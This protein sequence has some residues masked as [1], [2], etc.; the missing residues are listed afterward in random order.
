LRDKVEKKLTIKLKKEELV[1]PIVQYDIKPTYYIF[2]GI[3]FTVLTGNYIQ[4]F[5]GDCDAPAQLMMHII[6]DTMKEDRQGIVVIRQ[7]FA[8]ESNI[9]YHNYVNGIVE[10]VN[11]EKIVD[12][13][14]MIKKIEATKGE[15][16]ELGLED[17]RN[18]V[19]EFKESEKASPGILDRYR[20][21]ADRSDDLKSPA[22]K[23]DLPDL[24]LI[25]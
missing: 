14:D 2:G 23:T 17:S 13:K 4:L 8:D 20:I 7:V 10:T 6:G 3:V 22:Q 15:F 21:P 1:V 12:I 24:N 19:L 5:G 25:K 9:G 16:L 18:I 11:G